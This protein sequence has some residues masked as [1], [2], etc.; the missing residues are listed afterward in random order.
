MSAE[1]KRGRRYQ[2]KPW[3]LRLRHVFSVSYMD[4]ADLHALMFI[5]GDH[6][7][8]IMQ[9]ALREFVS[10]HGLPTNDIEFQSKLYLTASKLISEN[11]EQP[12]QVDVLESMGESHI[13][14]KIGD[15]AKSQLSSVPTS[16][17]Q[18]AKQ[19]PTPKALQPTPPKADPIPSVH[20]APA[21]PAQSAAVAKPRLPLPVMDLGPEISENEMGAS[22][23]A[24][25]KKP[26]LKDRWLARHK[27]QDDS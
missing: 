7:T 9:R 23:G 12:D 11:R 24:E 14:E 3:D 16:S 27:D 18:P 10:N 15:L 5:S 17:I 26:P 19:P 1:N 4:E 13:I 6:F 2:N 25:V 21:Q 20:T 22:P 8:A